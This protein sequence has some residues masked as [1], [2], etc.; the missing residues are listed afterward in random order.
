MEEGGG[1]SLRLRAKVYVSLH[2]HRST[3]NITDTYRKYRKLYTFWHNG[4]NNPKKIKSTQR[5]PSNTRNM[6]LR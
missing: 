4:K 2:T 3:N 1:L 6:G 5:L